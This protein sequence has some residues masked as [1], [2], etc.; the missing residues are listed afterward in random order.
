M[1]SAVLVL[2]QES[3]SSARLRL[4]FGQNLYVAESTG[5]LHSADHSFTLILFCLL[6]LDLSL[7]FEYWLGHGLHAPPPKK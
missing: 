4:D 2:Q 6:D 7:V 5:G 3:I 1:F